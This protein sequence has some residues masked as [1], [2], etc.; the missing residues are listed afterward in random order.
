MAVAL[1]LCMIISS[2]PVDVFT[3]M[4]QKQ[5]PIKNKKENDPDHRILVLKYGRI[6]F[7]TT[8]ILFWREMSFWHAHPRSRWHSSFW[9]FYLTISAFQFF[10]GLNV[11]FWYPL[12]QQSVLYKILHY[13]K[14]ITLF[15]VIIPW[16]IFHNN[17]V[18]K[19]PWFEHFA[20]FFQCTKPFLN[21]TVIDVCMSDGSQATAVVVAGCFDVFP[22]V[23]RLRW[24]M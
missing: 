15:V 16:R 22:T 5:F 12:S 24:C 4:W 8:L 1:T 18:H 10:V 7:F 17:Y 23:W 14:T 9:R 11:R 20:S 3:A 2:F 19:S 6:R 13:C 21:R